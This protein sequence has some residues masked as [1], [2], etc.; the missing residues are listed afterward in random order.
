MTRVILVGAAGRMGTVLRGKLAAHFA[1]CEL[2]A[3]VDVV[4]VPDVPWFNDIAAFDGEADVIVEFS[5]H[6]CV[7]SVLPWAVKNKIPVVLASTGHT[8]EEKAL[9]EEAAKETAIFRSANMSV[10]VA[11]LCDLAEKTAKVFPDA[12]IEI[13]ETHHNRKQD[14]P[15]GTALML[16]DRLAAARNGAKYTY[17]R[18]GVAPR[19]KDEI[20]IHAVRMGNITGKHEV[21]IGTDA[22]TV[23]LIHE[24]HT[25]EVFADGAL[26]AAA[27]IVGRPAGIYDMNDLIKE[28]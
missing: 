6:A 18:Q 11:L 25:R 28:E 19:A 20:G 4:P 9:I 10:G 16:A 3:A 21:I 23:T 17:G 8:D 27:F 26:S 1:G 5:N 22:Q 24:A 12:D 15:S 14:A 13:V 2:A 7:G